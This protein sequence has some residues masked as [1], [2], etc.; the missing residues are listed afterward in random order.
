MAVA[1]LDG[2][3]CST[4]CAGGFLVIMFGCARWPGAPQCVLE[5][6]FYVCVSMNLCLGGLGN[7]SVHV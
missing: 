4:M 6:P 7:G 2:L 5:T 1:M 3:V